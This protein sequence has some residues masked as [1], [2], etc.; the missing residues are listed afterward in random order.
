M[1]LT[2]RDHG[3]ALG[4]RKVLS[5]VLTCAK[6]YGINTTGESHCWGIDKVKSVG[7]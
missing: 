5:T 6:E 2:Q 7:K 4:R 1:S 3:Y